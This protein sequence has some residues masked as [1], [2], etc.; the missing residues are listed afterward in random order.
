MY[1]NKL[2]MERIKPEIERLREVYSENP[3]ELSKRVMAIY[4]RNGIKFIDRTTIMNIGSQ[5]VLGLGIFQVLKDMENGTRFMW[6]TDIAK[7]DVIL[8]IIVGVLTFLSMQVSP[9]IAEQQSHLMF[10]IPAIISM[11]VLV[12]FPSA[13]GLYWAT[14]NVVTTVQSL[15]LRMIILKEGNSRGGN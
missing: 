8:A 15:V 1:K 5:G 6:I 9:G 3:E 2:A 14:S 11:F 12:S 4:K 13:L 10:L 7:P